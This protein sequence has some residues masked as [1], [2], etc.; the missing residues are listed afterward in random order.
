M[1]PNTNRSTA[2]AVSESIIERLERVRNSKVLVYVTGDRRLISSTPI[3]F[4]LNAQ[5]HS[6]VLPIFEKLLSEIS[7][8]EKITLGIYTNGGAIELPWPLVS[9]IREYCKEFEV[10]VIKKALSAG[11]LVAVGADKIVMPKG[12]FLSPIDPARIQ[13]KN[14]ARTEL[15]IED[16]V[17]FIDFAKEK[18]GVNDQTTL[19]AIIQELAKEISPTVIGSI[20]RTHSLIRRL[21]AKLLDLHANKMPEHQIKELVEHL[22]QKLFSHKHLISRREAA[23]IGFGDMIVLPEGDTESAIVSLTECFTNL[24]KLDTPLNIEEIAA[25]ELAISPEGYSEDCVIAAIHSNRSKYNFSAKVTLKTTPT[26]NVNKNVN[27]NI[28]QAGWKKEED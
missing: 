12:S 8:T 17:G 11:T 25:G 24:L 4:S 15:Q 22:T 3:Q 2:Q 16:I 1:P 10:I 19:G 18:V 28:A 21:A 20:N 13:V 23:E 26:D 27:L 9:M 6:D 14:N 5:L 7:E